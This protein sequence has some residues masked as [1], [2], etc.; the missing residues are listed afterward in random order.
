MV[1]VFGLVPWENHISRGETIPRRMF[2]KPVT[3]ST[4]VDKYHRNDC[5]PKQSIAV[6][7]IP[8]CDLNVINSYPLNASKERILCLI[9]WSPWE[10]VE[11]GTIKSS[12]YSL[13]FI[14]ENHEDNGLQQIAFCWII[15]LN[16]HAVSIKIINNEV[17]SN[18]MQKKIF[19]W[20]KW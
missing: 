11:S 4:I 19:N 3:T 14:E 20:F 15:H 9:I 6:V 1:K 17:H 2:Q 18:A 13:L 10:F 7:T 12:W 5:K 8:N 16:P